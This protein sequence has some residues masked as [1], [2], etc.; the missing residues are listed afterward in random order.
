MK[1]LKKTLAVLLCAGMMW[2]L[3]GCGSNDNAADNGTV[4]DATE[5]TGNTDMGGDTNRNDNNDSRVL[6]DGVDDAGDAIRDG[7]DDVGDAV[8]DGADDLDGDVQNNT[9]NNSGN[10]R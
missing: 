7:V 5:N 4:N 6:E 3:T 2:G 10:N 1:Q 8:R 9:G